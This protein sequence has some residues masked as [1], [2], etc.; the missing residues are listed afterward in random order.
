MYLFRDG[1]ER[2]GGKEGLGGGKR[3]KKGEKDIIKQNRRAETNIRIK[4]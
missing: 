1:G 4:L 2:R 3:E